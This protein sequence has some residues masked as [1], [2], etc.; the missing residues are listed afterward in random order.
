VSDEVVWLR[1]DEEY[2]QVIAQADVPHDPK[3]GRISV[4]RVIA[5]HHEEFT[6]I[7]SENIT[8]MDVSTQQL[9]GVAASLIPFL[10]H[11][12]ANR[13][14]MGSNMQRQAVPL[15]RPQLALVATGMEK[16]VAANSGML[17]CAEGDGVVEYA[18]GQRLVV[19]YGQG[20]SA[21]VVEYPL[22]KYFGLN[23]RTCLNQKPIVR[24]GD[25]VVT[26]QVMTEGAATKDG[27]LALGSNTLVAFMSWEGYNFED[28]IVV[29]ERCVRNDMF[30][31]IHIE[32]FSCEVRE[33]KLGREEITRDIPNVSEAALAQLDEHGLVRV[34]AC[35]KPSDILVGK[36]APK[37][38]SELSSE[39]KLLHAIFGRAGEDVKNDSQTV[40]PG[41][42]GYVIRVDRFTRASPTGD[43]ERG[44][45]RKL[46]R[47]YETDYKRRMAEI[48]TNK[49]EA[50]KE[51][52]GGKLVNAESGQRYEFSKT[53]TDD[54]I[55]AVDAA[56][57]LNKVE[58][59][60]KSVV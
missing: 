40:K 23:E 11:D 13:A 41:V 6:E 3:T 28:A 44:E 54:E 21:R 2:D 39:E 57:D 5:R 59:D 37:S 42:E 15:V 45:N 30:T 35:V 43:D 47:K 10:E 26:E 38:K 7:P 48:V 27:E 49:F 9:V 56:L 60:R 55:L 16:P 46:I 20:Q 12:D 25:K 4:D 32:E 51:I 1:A 34:G 17:L 18:D 31:S 36:I 29:S 24:T 53:A 22:R 33:T 52:I 50:L 14:L 58:I 8:Y 19:R